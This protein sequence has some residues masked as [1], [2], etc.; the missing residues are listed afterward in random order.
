MLK[1]GLVEPEH[2]GHSPLSLVVG[3]ITLSRL[4]STHH[5]VLPLSVD[6]TGGVPNQALKN[7][8]GFG[9]W[10]QDS[11]VFITKKFHANPSLEPIHSQ[12]DLIF[13][14]PKLF[15][16]RFLDQG[17]PWKNSKNAQHSLHAFPDSSIHESAASF[18]P[19]P[20]LDVLS[21]P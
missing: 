9:L 15:H 10:E 2:L 12:L 18:Y 19:K 8:E 17:L 20:V 1:V 21:F 13:P 14:E 16:H 7:L 6:L 5:L 4:A 11:Q 3:S